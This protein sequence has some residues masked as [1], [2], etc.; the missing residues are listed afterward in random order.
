M[1]LSFFLSIGSRR[2]FADNAS[3]VNSRRERSGDEAH[4]SPSS[5]QAPD[6]GYGWVI[7]AAVFMI[8]VIL[9]GVTFSFSMLLP[10]ILEE[11]HASK[12][13]AS[14]VN[15]ILMGTTFFCGQ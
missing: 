2:K 14:S 4:E 3:P 5:S 12:G 9:D 7:V 13:S 15:S 10:S 6:G 8:H 11:F 1:Y